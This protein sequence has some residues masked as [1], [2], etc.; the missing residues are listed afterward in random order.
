MGVRKR[1]K[2]EDYVSGVRNGDRMVIAKA[3]TLLESQ[4]D[5]DIELSQEVLDKLLPHT[6][7]SIRLGISGIPGVGK[8]TFIESFG[9][10]LLSKGHKLA[11]LTI[12]PSSSSTKGSILGDKTRMEVLSK[13]VDVLIRPSP[14]NTVL[15]GVAARTREAILICEAAG[16]DYIIIETVGV[17]QSETQVKNMV[18]YFL[19]LTLSGTGD[20]LQGI[21]KGIMEMA[22]GIAINKVE[23][24]NKEAS[25]QSRNYLEQA[26]HMMP[27][28][29]SGVQPEVFLCSSL[30]R[31][32]I[33][34]I[35]DHIDDFIK[36][37]TKNGYFEKNRMD[38]LKMWLSNQVQ[39]FLI[40]DFQNNP[41][42]QKNMKLLEQKVLN[43]E[44]T[45]NQAC[46][47][48]IE[49]YRK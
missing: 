23:E 30:N 49:R 25:L 18:D 33:R 7:K 10:E 40:R 34:E 41:K 2:V 9:Q 12:D 35:A 28:N 3:I 14:T 38:Q 6:E 19:L 36:Q 48:A 11:I 37:T 47:T 5:S 13:N 31:S 4:L 21:K 15:G 44:L 26:L 22:N 1:L 8:S 27:Q 20:D 17:G 43:K 24:P 16:Y 32:G 46:K 45:V 39:E 42:T 29:K